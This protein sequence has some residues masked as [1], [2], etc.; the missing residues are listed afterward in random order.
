[1]SDEFVSEDNGFACCCT[2][3]KA[4]LLEGADELSLEV[5]VLSLREGRSLRLYLC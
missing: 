2:S 3:R 4:E 1:M 5:S